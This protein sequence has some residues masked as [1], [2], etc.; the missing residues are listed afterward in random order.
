MS[1]CDVGIHFDSSPCLQPVSGHAASGFVDAVD[2]ETKRD[3]IWKI[4]KVRPEP[5]DLSKLKTA[6]KFHYAKWT[7]IFDHYNER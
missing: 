7:N 3:I 5:S 4:K 2:P 1:D 6:C